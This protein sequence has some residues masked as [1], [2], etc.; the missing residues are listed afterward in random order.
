MNHIREPYLVSKH[1]K[2][3]VSLLLFMLFVFLS[4]RKVF[5][6]DVRYVTPQMFGAVADG[7][8]DDSD[9]VQ[10]AIDS[11]LP[12]YLP[13]GEYFITKPIKVYNKKELWVQ[14][15]PDALIHRQH[16][17]SQRVYL[18]NLQNCDSCMFRDLNITSEI[19]GVGKAPNGH[20]RP[21]SASSN[22]LAFGGNRNSKI[23]FYNNTFS[24][25]ESDFWFNDPSEGWNTIYINGWESTNST[26][27]LYGQKCNKL[28]IS[29]ADVT[30]NSDTAGDGD[31]CIY[32]AQNSTDITI[33]DSYFDAGTGDYGE[34]SPGAVFTFYR[35][36]NVS[37]DQVIGDVNIKNCTIRGGRFLYGNCGEAETISASDCVFEQT[38]SR[39]KDYTGAFGGDTNYKIYNS[40]IYVSTYTV[41]GQQ[42]TE[43]GI[44]FYNCDID[45]ENYNTVCFAD[46]TNLWVYDCNINV[47][48]TLLY[49]RESNANANVTFNNCSVYA[50]NNTYL[51][52]KRNTNGKV[53]VTNTII[54]NTQTADNL[55]YNGKTVDMSGFT[56]SGCTINGYKTIANSSN[57]RNGIITNTTINGVS[58]D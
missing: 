19:E 43:T 38:F 10:S 13:A 48:K 18:F 14:G 4:D 35:S 34:G 20:T 3:K 56:I 40:E 23:Y 26:M 2:T 30:L 12:V 37:E 9:A 17:A 33:R 50:A 6:E 32:I 45:V 29:N 58:V 21:S 36:G 46:P 7:V 24:N 52:S 44:V 41:T 54:E 15:S 11:G 39:G 31:H 57:I 28:T 49:I 42:T 5:A 22:I 47:G 27:A 16:H 1:T 25:M 8:A 55:V 51:L 53:V